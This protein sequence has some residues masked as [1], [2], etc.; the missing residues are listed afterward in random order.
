MA[1]CPTCGRQEPLIKMTKHH[2][3]PKHKGGKSEEE[4][5]I[6]LCGDC[7]TQLHLLY[8]NAY[9]RDNLNSAELVL[10]DDRL[11]KFGRF[12]AKQTKRINK[13]KSSGR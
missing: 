8:D 12:A 1:A 6:W 13:R 5:Y 4:N 7:H 2:M 11:K 3:V 9:L 10:A